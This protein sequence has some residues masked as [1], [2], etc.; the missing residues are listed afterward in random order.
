MP[1][2]VIVVPMGT[3]PPVVTEFIQYVEKVLNERVSDLTMIATREPLVGEGV[4]LVKTALKA[5]YPHIHVHVAELPF[6]DITSEE[7]SLK[8]MQI[9][10]QILRSQRETHGADILYLCVAGGRKDMCITLSL[11]AQYSEVNGVFHVIVPDVKTMNIELERVR[12]NITE[13][14]K[15]QDKDGYYE[16]YK[17]VFDEIMFPPL[18][19]Y[20]AIRIPVLPY[21][22]T[23]MNDV[24][25]L[26]T[27][28]V[29]QPRSRV[30]LP[31][32][33]LQSM[34]TSRLIKLTANNIY[35]T[36]E[37]REFGE[38]LKLALGVA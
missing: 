27:G 2:T 23:L 31:L 7:E 33:V 15:S 9:S 20:T 28:D 5:R 4:E 32:M 21:P 1:K 14:T 6:T 29:T 34:H 18:S 8:F 26:L 36:S 37:G 24:I 3:S 16:Q 25:R 12:H 11:V 19:E 38:T 13:L 10:A 30:K 17:E 35:V 22:R